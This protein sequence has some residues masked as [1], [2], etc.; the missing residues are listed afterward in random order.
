MRKCPGGPVRIVF[1]RVQSTWFKTPAMPSWHSGIWA[2]GPKFVKTQTKAHARNIFASLGPLQIAIMRSCIRQPCPTADSR[3][4]I[5][6]RNIVFLCGRFNFLFAQK[7]VRKCSVSLTLIIFGLDGFTVDPSSR[8]PIKRFQATMSSNVSHVPTFSDPP[9]PKIYDVSWAA[10]THLHSRTR[11]YMISVIR[12][13]NLN[14]VEFRV[15]RIEFRLLTKTP[16]SAHA[17]E[18]KENFW[19][20]ACLI[21]RHI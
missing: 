2:V 8:G 3:D 13:K 21:R 1:S 10:V 11:T 20:N 18:K 14:A 15:C 6:F 16:F 5:I 17:S 9:T 7:G 19:A 4:A 12:R